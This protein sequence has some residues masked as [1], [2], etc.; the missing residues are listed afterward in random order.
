MFCLFLTSFLCFLEQ[1]WVP[2]VLNL[3]QVYIQRI[4]ICLVFCKKKSSGKRLAQYVVEPIVE[5]RLSIGR[6]LQENL[7]LHRTTYFTLVQVQHINRCQLPFLTLM[8]LLVHYL[9]LFF[10]PSFLAHNSLD[11]SG[12]CLFLCT[13][14]MVFRKPLKREKKM[15]Q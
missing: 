15:N 13:N 2:I 8:H 3:V 4:V 7:A 14:I 5:S 11:S 6:H 12:W 10:S 1:F 9:L